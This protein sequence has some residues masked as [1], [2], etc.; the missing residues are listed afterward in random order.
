MFSHEQICVDDMIKVRKK[1]LQLN[2]SLS[3]IIN[4]LKLIILTFFKKIK[5]Q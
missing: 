2:I 4:G 5:D 3:I 1:Y